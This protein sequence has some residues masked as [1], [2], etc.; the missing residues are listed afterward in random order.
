MFNINRNQ[1][2][3]LLTILKKHSYVKSKSEHVIPNGILKKTLYKEFKPSCVI[4]G[5]SSPALGR[6]SNGYLSSKN[7]WTLPYGGK[8]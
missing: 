7:E 8:K 6:L 4:H 1:L 2:F 3:L 5:M